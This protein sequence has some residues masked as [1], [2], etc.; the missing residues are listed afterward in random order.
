M[1]SRAL[2]PAT[3][4]RAAQ[5]LRPWLQGRPL[6]LFD[7]DGTLAP[8]QSHRDTVVLAQ[9]LRLDLRRLARR[10][11]VAVVSGRGLA[12]L[13][14]RLGRGPWRSYGSHGAEGQGGAQARRAQ[15]AFTATRQW[16]AAHR[17]ELLH[18]GLD[19]EDKV[20][21]AAL[22]A[23]QGVDLAAA[24]CWLRRQGL[25]ASVHIEAGHRVINLS[26]A[27]LPDKGDAAR[28]ALRCSGATALL[29]F[30]DDRNDEPAFSAA[31]RCGLAF[32]VGAPSAAT[33][34]S[35][36][37]WRLADSLAVARLVRRLGRLRLARTARRGLKHR[38]GS[39]RW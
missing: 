7:F 35:A 22:H 5:L 34:P 8:L 29:A 9:P 24:L 15:Q 3:H 25:G 16:C 38:T 6:L 19:W 14:A 31:R 23:A 4:S 30:G 27:G 2:R 26:A 33:E 13:R 17:S 1:K 28:H 39:L 36:A 21:C 32:R 11:P 10:W 18:A 12:D 37:A 20:C